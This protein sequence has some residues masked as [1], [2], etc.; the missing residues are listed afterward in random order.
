V[1]GGCLAAL[2]ANVAVGAVT[3]AAGAS[4]DFSPLT[5]A[6]LVTPTIFATVLGA[7]GWFVIARRSVRPWE[8]FR[9][10]APAVVLLSLVPDVIMWID[11]S[12]PGISAGAVLGLMATHAATGIV[13]V[14]VFRWL[15]PVDQQAARSPMPTNSDPVS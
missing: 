4:S 6:E 1:I 11:G 15:M 12:E 14:A 9:L 3:R 13:L 5:P 2:A 10:V 8:I 7:V